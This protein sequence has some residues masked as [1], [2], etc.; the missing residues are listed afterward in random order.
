MSNIP[1]KLRQALSKRGII[2]KDGSGINEWNIL[3]VYLVNNNKKHNL[4]P[5]KFNKFHE[6]SLFCAKKYNFPDKSQVSVLW[7]I[8]FCLFNFKT[9]FLHL[10]LI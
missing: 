2:N 3:K 8:K 10:K 1:E 4:C 9:L 6:C 5:N 7:L